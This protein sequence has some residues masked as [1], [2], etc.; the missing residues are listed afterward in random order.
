MVLS[1]GSHARRGQIGVLVLQ[2]AVQSD[3]PP[4]PVV[5]QQGQQ[6]VDLLQGRSGRHRVPEMRDGCSQ[7]GCHFTTSFMLVNLCLLITFNN[8]CGKDSF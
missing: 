8:Y 1:A 4:L 3:A 5:G 7:S 6:R 2:F